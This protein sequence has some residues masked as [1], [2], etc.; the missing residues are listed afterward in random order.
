MFSWDGAQRDHVNECL[1]RNELPNLAALIAEGTTSAR[2]HTTAS[3]TSFL[4]MSD[5]LLFLNRTGDRIHGYGTQKAD[6]LPPRTIYGI[7]V[8]WILA[9]TLLDR[10]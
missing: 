9:G 5:S 6:L 8:G 7:G 3:N 4:I 2:T 10:R 1:S